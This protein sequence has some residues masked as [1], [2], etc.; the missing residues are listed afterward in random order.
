MSAYCISPPDLALLLVDFYV[1]FHGKASSPRPRTSRRT[2][3]VAVASAQTFSSLCK[4]R[5]IMTSCEESPKKPLCAKPHLGLLAT[6]NALNPSF[7]ITVV[8]NYPGVGVDKRGWT[9]FGRPKKHHG[10]YIGSDTVW[11]ASAL[12]QTVLRPREK[13]QQEAS[14]S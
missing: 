10:D 1:F 5:V 4:K 7:R 11:D 2:R 14:S 9:G 8:I 12:L 6:Q 3:C 13:M